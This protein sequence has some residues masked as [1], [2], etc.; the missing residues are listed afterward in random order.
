MIVEGLIGPYGGG[1]AMPTVRTGGTFPCWRDRLHGHA[2]PNQELRSSDCIWLKLDL[3]GDA[4][5]SFKLTN[6]FFA[7]WFWIPGESFLFFWR[8]RLG[9][10]HCRLML[11]AADV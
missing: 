7:V 1:A 9:L 10:G 8:D 4:D 3:I 5:D 11:Q 6:Q 2:L